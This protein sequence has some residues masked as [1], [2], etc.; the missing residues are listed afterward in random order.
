MDNSIFFWLFL[1]LL[2]TLLFITFLNSTYKSGSFNMWISRYSKTSY[3]ATYSWFNGFVSIP[4]KIDTPQEKT[5]T[6]E[7]N[8]EKES[9]KLTLTHP[10]KS[11]HPIEICEGGTIETTKTVEFPTT[12]KYRLRIIGKKTK[13]SFDVK[14]S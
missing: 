7:I 6:Y 13:G 9:L 11:E 3:R 14:W 5:F 2:S 12:G 8:V 1:V 4:I 10:N